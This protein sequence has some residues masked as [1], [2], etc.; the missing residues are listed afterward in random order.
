MTLRLIL[1]ISLIATAAHAQSAVG[2]ASTA[3]AN[4]FSFGDAGKLHLYGN[5][6]FRYDTNPVFLPLNPVA[7]FALRARAGLNL[8]RPSEKL[9]LSL[10]VFGEWTQWMGL[11]RV[12]TR[13][14]STFQ[15]MINFSLLANKEGK[16]TFFLDENLSRNDI[17]ANAAINQ[18]LRSLRTLTL[19][20]TDFRPRSRAL[21]FR[22]AYSLD[23]T[24]YDRDQISVLNPDSLTFMTH[25]PQLRA[26]WRFFPRTAVVLEAQGAFTHYPLQDPTIPTPGL[27][28]L[29][30]MTGLQGLVTD[31]IEVVAKAGYGNSFITVAAG[32]SNFSSVIAQV[33]LAWRPTDTTTLGIGYS[34][35][36]QPVPIFG[37]YS[38][39]RPW[40]EAQQLLFGRIVASLRAQYMY[41][42]FGR[43]AVAGVAP[44]ADHVVFGEARVGYQIQRWLRGSIYYQPDFRFSAFVSPRG[45]SGAYERHVIGMDL[46]GGY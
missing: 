25:T 24:F 16:V 45:V 11:V 34:R 23:F 21:E 22:A 18:R 3:E 13:E 20:G 5:L 32:L 35:D 17:P 14:L 4:G 31:K 26:L 40:L 19:L 38:Y 44:R 15:A 30:V 29:R 43:P 8:N 10:G 39:D 46:T 37:W 33:S 7:D 12:S 41:Q 6:D 28:G 9:D 42:L 2:T 27:N 36:F 1:L